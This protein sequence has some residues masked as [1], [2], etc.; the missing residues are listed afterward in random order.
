[1]LTPEEV[2]LVFNCLKTNTNHLGKS[3]YMSNE[4]QDRLLALMHLLLYACLRLKEAKCA[5]WSQV[6]F[7]ENAFDVEPHKTSNSDADSVI[8]PLNSKLKEFLLE[9]RKKYPDEKYIVP[10]IE[11]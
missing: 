7:D 6:L 9:F 1:V 2:K 8:I 11:E 3:L 4:K 5:L 10:H